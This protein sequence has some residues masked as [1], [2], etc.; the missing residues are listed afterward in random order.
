MALMSSSGT[1]LPRFFDQFEAQPGIR[2]QKDDKMQIKDKHF[3][4]ATSNLLAAYFPA[5]VTIV[6]YV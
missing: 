2:R 6:I 3:F 5:N 1:E 4:I